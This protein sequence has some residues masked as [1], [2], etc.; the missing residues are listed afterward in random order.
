MIRRWPARA[1]SSSTTPACELQYRYSA[2]DRLCRPVR[3]EH[4]F[5]DQ[6]FPGTFQFPYLQGT[7][8]I[9]RRDR[10]IEAGGFDENIF[11]Y[12]DDADICGRLIDAGWVIRQ[13][14]NSP[15]HHKFL[16]SGIRDHQ[17]ITTN[18]FPVVHDH[19]YFALR[20]A[21]PYLSEDE[22]LHHVHEFIAPRRGGH[23]DARG[24]WSTAAWSRRSTPRRRACRAFADGLPRRHGV[25]R[26]PAAE[27]RA[28]ATSSSCASRR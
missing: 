7:N 15:V 22:I 18:W 10:L 26:S 6:C 24:G 25:D 14:P 11:F 19:T 12:G 16:P 9:Y 4:E 5:A 8:Q 2:T 13:L 23:E 28:R 1:A 3:S 17:R 27:A 20:H 21:S